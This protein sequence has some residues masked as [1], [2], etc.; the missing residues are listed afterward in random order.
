MPLLETFA[1]ASARGFGAFLP[2]GGPAGAY[3][4]I[5]TQILG[6]AAATVEFTSIPATY[7][8]LQFRITARS[9]ETSQ[10]NDPMFVTFNGNT[11]GYAYHRIYGTGG[12]VLSDQA[13]AQSNIRMNDIATGNSSFV[14]FTGIILD[15]LDYKE[16]TKNKTMRAFYGAF[17]FAFNN[18][19]LQSGLLT[20]TSAITSVLFDLNISNFVAGSRFTL[21]GIKG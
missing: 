7:K 4:Q 12:G 19:N 10:G 8:H 13:N 16:T 15:L 3:E 2:A 17:T 9:A 14:G 1:N 5:S 21:Y 20:S 11:S 18:I 6:S